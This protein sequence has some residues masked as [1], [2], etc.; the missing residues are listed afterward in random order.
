MGAIVR[1]GGLRKFAIDLPDKLRGGTNRFDTIVFLFPYVSSR[2][3]ASRS[4][5]E[6]QRYHVYMIFFCARMWNMQM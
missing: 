1:T 5:A 6:I 2:R 4:R 3:F